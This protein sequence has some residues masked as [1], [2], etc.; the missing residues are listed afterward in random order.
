MRMTFYRLLAVAVVAMM[1]A[2]ACGGGTA[3]TPTSPPAKATPTTA[4]QAAP[5]ATKA[6]AA[7]PTSAPAATATPAATPTS[8]PKPAVSPTASGS[9]PRY[10]GTLTIAVAGDPANLDPVAK[11]PGSTDHDMIAPAYN[12]LVKYDPADNMKVVGDLAKSWTISPDGLTYTFLLNQGVKWHD[13]KP[14]TA[15]DV[16]DSIALIRTTVF[17]KDFFGAV[18]SITAPDNTT[19]QMTLSRA[20]AAFIK[21]AAV[22]KNYI[23]A[24]HTVKTLG[25]LKTTAAG[26]GPFK[27]V[28]YAKGVQATLVKNPD[29]FVQGRPY[30]D[31]INVFPIADSATRIAQFRTNKVMLFGAT[32]ALSPG[33]ADELKRAMP[34]ANIQP[35]D[36]ASLLAININTSSG[37]WQNV[38]VRKAVLL[39]L[40]RNK[41][42]QVLGA[43]AGRPALSLIPPPYELTAAE[44]A[45]LPGYRYP[46]DA[47]IAEAKKLLTEAGYPTGF[48][49]TI[50]ARA[51][52]TYLRDLSVYFADELTKIGIKA[53]IEQADFGT[54]DSRRTKGAYEVL[55]ARCGLFYADPDSAI[56]Q[57]KPGSCLTYTNDATL[58]GLMD[59]QSNTLDDRQRAVILHKVQERVAETVPHLATI[60]SVN[61]MPMGANLKDYKVGYSLH[62]NSMMQNVWLAP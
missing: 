35:Y 50:L 44:F 62:N 9:Q 45:A 3:A 10:G 18:K 8:A 27:F 33:E 22:E 40:D 43:N 46:K 52:L 13:G 23:V 56:P 1:L 16:V 25:D 58:Q 20:Q 48:S 21:A 2:A 41:A 24:P 36:I 31:G 57:L 53:T 6:P 47:D 15:Q 59:E 30:L 12:G 29:Y 37:P 32:S 14:L 34:Q 11:W 51:D 39:A 4:T 55:T 5:T 19:V 61:F 7:S 17:R 49:T 54:Y 38:K 60:W 42:N 26:T 28:S